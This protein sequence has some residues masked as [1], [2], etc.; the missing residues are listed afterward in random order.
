MKLRYTVRTLMVGLLAS[1]L[2]MTA[3]TG[4]GSG[5]ETS[6]ETVADTSV[7]T[8]AATKAEEETLAATETETEAMTEA[9]TE[10]AT[11]ASTEP[12]TEPEAITSAETEATVETT[13][14]ET[15]AGTEDPAPIDTLTMSHTGGVYTE[16]ISLEMSAPEGQTIRYTTDGSVPTKR[17]TKYKE[18][19]EVTEDALTIRA[20]CFDE[21]GKITGDVVTNTY[22]IREAKESTLYTVMI[23]VDKDDLGDMYDNVNAKI[24]RPAHVEIV[25]PDGETVISQDAGLRLFGGSSRSLQQKSFKLIAR[26]TGYF[27]EDAAYVGQGTFRYALFPERV[28]KG[29]AKVGQVLDRY[30]SF[31]LRNGGNDSLL[32]TACNPEDATL[33]RDGLANNFAADVTTAVEYSYSQYAVVY[34]NGNYYGL[35]DMR[36]NLNEDF[37]KRVWGV[38]DNDVVV[39]KS[40]LDITR[41]CAD[42]DNGGGCRYCGSWFFYE[43]DDSEMA[44]NTLNEWL[45]FCEEICGKV[46]AND[47]EYNAAFQKLEANVDLVGLKEWYALNLYLCNTDWPHNNI[48]L[49]KY[50]GEPVEG[51][52]ITDGKWRFMTRD[53]DMTMGRYSRPELTS[54]LDSRAKVDS[55]WRTLGNYIPAYH[56]IYSDSGETK[57]YADAL[58]LQG[59]FAF[60][61]R[62]DEFRAEFTAYCREL[63][64]EEKQALLEQHYDT[65]VAQV[66][67]EMGAYI[68]RWSRVIGS[69]YAVRDWTRARR[70]LTDFMKNRPAKFEAYLDLCLSMYK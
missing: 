55:F 9:L 59:L 41:A 53:M 38:D 46:N 8:E 68:E 63:I 52:E 45:K 37:V 22:V 31:I 34:I 36:E 11:D 26:K 33:I 12:T 51:I 50:T 49:W 35:L 32:H 13:L 64:S 60:C 18:A 4:D 23:S 29:G 57:L 17:S 10:A 30:D 39:I 70:S 1:V 58:Y 25:T 19:I 21:S 20:A 28:I 69:N 27:G 7:V 6:A 47:A 5:N 66:S 24:E 56:D 40:E 54:D 43:T 15:E 67:P 2:L 65:L 3:C 42:H 44:Q 62:N 16:A 14:A 48:K 61:M